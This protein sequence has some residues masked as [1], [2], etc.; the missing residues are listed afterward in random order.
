MKYPRIQEWFS[1]IAQQQP[2]SSAV[3][4][5]DEAFTYQYLEERSNN[6]ANFLIDQ[7]ASQG[8][9]V[10]ILAQDTVEVIVAIL[11]T[12][13]AGAV[14]VPLAPQIPEGRL[15]AIATSIEPK[16]WLIESPFLDKLQPL[17]NHVLNP[18]K[19]IFLDEVEMEPA[20]AQPL[21]LLNDYRNYESLTLPK[22]ESDLDQ[23]CYIYFTSGST[24]KPKG[25]AGRLQAI[26]H[27]V[28]WEINFL[29]LT[30]LRS[31]QL[32]I[33]S[34]DA[35]LRDIFVPLCSGG[36]LCLPPGKET[37]LDTRKLI[38]WLDEQNINLIHCV[39]S[40]FRSLLNQN[41][42][43]D[44]FQEL[45]YI[46]MAGE[47]LLPA[48]V[49]KWVSCFGDRVQLVNLYGA[50]ETTMTKFYYPVAPEDGERKSIPVG[51]PIPGATLL[52]VNEN[53]E[54]C[55]PGSE[56]EIYVQTP[57]RTLGYYQQPELTNKVFVPNPLTGDVDDIVYK[58]GDLGKLQD[59]GNLEFLGRKDFQVKIRG[60]RIELAEI[61]NLL[62]SHPRI[63]DV[64]V[65][66][67]Q[68]TSGNKYLCAYTVTETP[69]EQGKLREFL[70]TNLPDYM[71]PSSFVELEA[72]PRNLNGKVDRKSLPDPSSIQRDRLEPRTEHEQKIATV[73]QNV[74]GCEKVGVTDNFFELGGHS[75]LAVRLC[76]SLEESLGQDVPVAALFQFPTVEGLA[77]FLSQDE[78]GLTGSSI[79]NIQSQGSRPPI[80]GIHVLGK[81]MAYYRPLV[82]HLGQDWPVYGLS[83]NSS[84]E[85]KGALK[86]V[87]ELAE[88]YIKDMQAIQPKGPY[89]LLGVSFGGRVAFE[90][91]QQLRTQGEEVALLG[92]IDT[93]ART[94][95]KHLPPSSRV[96]G[97]WGKFKQEGFSYITRKLKSRLGRIQYRLKAIRAKI[98]QRF[99]QQVPDELKSLANL[100]T[101]I[102]IK[103][104]HFP[105][106]YSGK[107]TLFRAMERQAEV[108]TEIDPQYGWGELAVGGLEIYDIPGDHLLMLQEPNVQVLAEKIK[109]LMQ[110]SAEGEEEQ[111]VAPSQDEIE[112]T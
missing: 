60:V 5:G 23:L 54:P 19:L 82:K 4:R 94:G 56:G 42:T 86:G 75:L 100:E 58:T 107:I 12:L 112:A 105:K 81:G 90:M 106:P 66:D 40:I 15:Q 79:I 103:K 22:Q 34:F 64:V 67:R 95:V 48:D 89:Y 70:L 30:E 62:R 27:F 71:I 101:N 24:G 32:V 37:L 98:Y 61:E 26:S 21:T 16:F 20:Q 17:T 47:P 46:L 80:F 91:A 38:R 77:N 14:F 25:I 65:V 41:L 83:S 43:S 29:K 35:F 110:Q 44:N 99:G 39:P 2:H 31:S 111:P 108:G 13:K 102:R 88:L 6:L 109:E 3:L 18:G 96:S 45:R 76:S 87:Q 97:H 36:T 33:P 73:W 69:I 85:V 8:S 49:K 11:G 63:K 9:I 7:G 10:V 52:L 1:A 59:D 50:S 72:L 104:Q 28:D 68:D 93:T 51:K 92:L 84:D 57:Y 53:N 78:L 55:K 74:L